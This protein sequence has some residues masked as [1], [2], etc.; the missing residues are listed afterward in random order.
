MAKDA[1]P[2][3]LH[4][5]PERTCIGCGRKAPKRRLLRFVA[6][7]GG[8][9]EFDPQQTMQGRGGYLCPERR[10]FQDASKKRRMAI[11]YRRPIVLDPDGWLEAARKELGAE[12]AGT[13]VQEPVEG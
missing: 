3:R 4:D 8:T 5:R 9:L 2:E 6:R 10:C 12:P 1:D 11:R 13:A 7:E